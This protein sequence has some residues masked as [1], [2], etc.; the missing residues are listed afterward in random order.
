YT[1]LTDLEFDFE[2]GKISD[3]DYE[4]LRHDLMLETAQV[5]ARIDE[6]IAAT[7]SGVP[8]ASATAAMHEDALEE[9]IARH[10]SG[11]TGGRRRVTSK[12]FE[13][14]LEQEIEAY[15][16]SRKEGA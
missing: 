8:A 14:E 2:C 3:A 1:A 16:S 5:L 4:E 7:G 15:R 6:R 9:E 11:R 13:D 10:R 12:Q